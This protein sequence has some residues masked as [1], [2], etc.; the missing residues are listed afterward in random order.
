VKTKLLFS[1]LIVLIILKT[2][3]AQQ[4]GLNPMNFLDPY[5]NNQATAGLNGNGLASM[6][7][8]LQWGNV[9]YSPRNLNLNLSSPLKTMNGAFGFAINNNSSGLLDITTLKT[10]YNYVLSKQN[11]L[12][13]S[14]IGLNYNW[15]K[16]DYEKIRTPEGSYLS[17]IINHNDPILGIKSL[18]QQ[19]FGTNFA[20]YIQTKIIDLG[21]EFGTAI[22]H[23]EN[24]GVRIHSAENILKIILYKEYNWDKWIFSGSF[25]NLNNFQFNQEEL[26]LDAQ[27]YNQY[28]GGLIF[29]GFSSNS[30]GAA[31]FHFDFKL[32]NNTWLSYLVE[33]SYK[34]VNPKFYGTSQ[35]Y[36]IRYEFQTKKAEDRF[37]I[38]YNPRW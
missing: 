13:S 37:P 22:Y 29:R 38:I 30:V 14:S 4:F 32:L 27:Y 23:V 8:R 16:L 3:L 18:N 10:S 6:T 35:Q 24:Q 5:N 31:G 25:L 1:V 11:F 20:L 7:Y 12:L 9:S 2:G 33:F 17:N 34:N 36:G 21:A 15:I 26:R 19:V 28:S